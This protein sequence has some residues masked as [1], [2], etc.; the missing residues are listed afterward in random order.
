MQEPSLKRL[1]HDDIRN[2]IERRVSDHLGQTWQVAHAVGKTAESSHP[3]ALLSNGDFTVFVKLNEGEL[4]EDQLAREVAGLRLLSRRGGVLTPDV[5]DA[6]RVADGALVIM[7]AVQSVARGPTQWRQIGH[8]L[9]QLH[10]V[11]GDRFGLETHCYW[12]GL[13]QDNSPLDDWPEF[14][15]TR[16]VLP[17]LQAALDSGNLPTGY[18]ARV[19]ALH[20][21]LHTLCGPAVQPS[22]LHG[23]AHQNNIISSA[24]GPV[25]IDPA[26]FYGHPEIDLAYL[27]MFAPVPPHVFDGYREIGSIDAG[28]SA[29][30]DLWRIPFWLGMV[31]VDG[32]QHVNMLGTILQRYMHHSP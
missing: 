32:P 8:A 27:D 21:R 19:E 26:V 12:G 2:S 3:A 18:V 30:R 17:R 7:V 23:D 15:W 28:F 1:L 13:Y 14:F 24:D 11:K 16:R 20:P 4:G 6:M 25:F 5:V 9:A 10:T 22:L 31:E 29:R